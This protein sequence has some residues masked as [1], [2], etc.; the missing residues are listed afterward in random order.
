MKKLV[1]Y[2]AG[3]VGKEVVSIIETINKNKQTYELL[4]F[5]TEAVYFQNGDMIGGY[6]WL[7]DKEWILKHKRDVYCACTIGDAGVRAAIQRDLAKQGVMFE[8]I[9]STSSHIGKDTE[10]GQ[11]CV[12]YRNV[13]VGANC[14][15]G[16]GVMLNHGCTVGHDTV[17]GDYTTV[18]TAS[19]ISGFCKVGSEVKI[20]GHAFIV[21]RKKIGDKSTVAA[22]SVV[23]TNVRA[24]TTVLGNPA[25]RMKEI[26]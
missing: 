23:F 26:E 3:S 17:V 13:S 4:G 20:G 5:I 21:P 8:T 14:K 12:F 7:G 19:G 2:G 24:G 10:I 15:I 6:P 16:N 18:M 22:G 11:G 1:L 25:K 9:I